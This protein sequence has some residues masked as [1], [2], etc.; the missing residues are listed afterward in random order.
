M[1]DSYSKPKPEYWSVENNNFMD[2]SDVQSI[3]NNHTHIP[4]D[5]TNN[6][7]WKII[8]IPVADHFDELV[9]L[10]VVCCV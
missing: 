10:Q 6:L 2:N 8:R 3:N 5:N 9:H 7:I 1:G 4:Y